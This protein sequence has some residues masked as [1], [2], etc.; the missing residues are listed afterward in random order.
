M[1][2]V[3]SFIKHRCTLISYSYT[4]FHITAQYLAHL[5]EEVKSVLIGILVQT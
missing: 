5:R 1:E 2:A 4:G 3:K